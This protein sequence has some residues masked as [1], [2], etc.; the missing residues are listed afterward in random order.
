MPIPQ[1][2]LGVVEQMKANVTYALPASAVQISYQDENSATLAISID[3]ANFSN[4]PMVSG[5]ALKT[6]SVSAVFIRS[7][8][9]TTYIAAKIP[10]G[11][12]IND[13]L[14]VSTIYADQGIF[15]NYVSIGTNPAQSGSLRLSTTGEISARNQAN[16]ADLDLIK[17]DHSISPNHIMVGDFAASNLDLKTGTNL[18]MY[19]GGNQAWII[20]PTLALFPAT[21]TQ[22]IG[23]AS[24]NRVRNIYSVGFLSIGLNAAQ[25]GAIRVTN[26]GGMFARNVANNGDLELFRSGP[27]NELV[28][29]TGA[30]YILVQ[31]TAFSNPDAT[32]DLGASSLRWRDCYLSSSVRIG[33]NPASAGAIRLANN[34]SISWRNAANDADISITASGGNALSLNGFGIVAAGDGITE[35]G[36]SNARWKNAHLSVAAY[37]GIAAVIGT[38]PA[39][40]GA[41]RLANDQ[42]I[43]W[44]NAANTADS[45]QIK[46][47][48]QG[49]LIFTSDVGTHILG[50]TGT[51]F[52]PYPTNSIDSGNTGAR[53]RNV[54]VAGAVVNRI[55]AGTPVDADVTNPADGMLM[56]DS[57]ANKIW[58]RLGGV[59]KGVVVA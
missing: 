35:L 23:L 22:D 19:A 29:G 18:V 48:D 32:N 5:S 3:G 36:Y 51:A 15:N 57:T 12:V 4:L 37:I 31:K 34:Q 20:D 49:Q 38:N 41:I 46:A 42:S 58:V 50:L 59:W 56:L 40:S 2:M 53:W 9:N 47:D 13:P 45:F 55:K 17:L 7:N 54:Y 11:L 1:L 30:A 26:T 27:N 8:S 6:I 16:S 33:T 21:D 43:S 44:R 28:I 39:Q 24:S 14:T 25:S 10:A 52:Y